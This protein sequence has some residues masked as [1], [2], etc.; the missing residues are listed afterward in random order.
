MA[1]GLLGIGYGFF[2]TYK[3]IKELEG[4]LLLIVMVHKYSKKEHESSNESN[5]H[6]AHNSSKEESHA[7]TNSLSSQ[8]HEVSS[9]DNTLSI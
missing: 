1:I 5:A 2:Y 6:E 9:D 8:K 3:D 4:F 7:Q